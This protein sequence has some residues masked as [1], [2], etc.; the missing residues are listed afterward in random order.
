MDDLEKCCVCFDLAD[1]SHHIHPQALGGAFD[2]AQVWLC[3]SCHTRIHNAA[4]AL[5]RNKPT[6][7]N[8]DWMLRARPLIMRIVRAMREAETTDLGDVQS[9]IIIKLPKK[10]IKRIHRRKID[11]G[12]KSL[13]QYFLALIGKD[14]PAE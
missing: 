10:Y 14:L 9:R 3:A 2:S 1:H 8:S 11:L 7:L 13:E 12:Y 5:F 4:N 6:D